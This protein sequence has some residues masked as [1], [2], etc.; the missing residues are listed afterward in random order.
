MAGKFRYLHVGLG[1]ILGFVGIKMLLANVYHLPTTISL[2]VI[3]VVLAVTVWASLGADRREH[4]RGSD[5]EAP[6]PLDRHSGTPGK[7]RDT[8]DPNGAGRTPPSGS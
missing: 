5:A 1:V 2:S 4:G 6:D 8:T 3:A 7:V